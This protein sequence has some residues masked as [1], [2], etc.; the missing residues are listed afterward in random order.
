MIT[1]PPWKAYTGGI[2]GRDR[3]GRF[4]HPADIIASCTTE[5]DAWAIAY[6]PAMITALRDFVQSCEY[7]KEGW[8]IVTDDNVLDNTKFLLQKLGETL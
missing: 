4:I 5:A 8:I 6:V 3:G 7:S 1:P 2:V